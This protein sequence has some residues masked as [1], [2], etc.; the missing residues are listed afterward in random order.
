[1]TKSRE[2]QAYLNEVEQLV[3]AMKTELDQT[4]LLLYRAWA[5]T[6]RNCKIA[7]VIASIPDGIDFQ[8][9]QVDNKYSVLIA[10]DTHGN[11]YKNI[12]TKIKELGFDS[13]YKAIEIRIKLNKSRVDYEHIL[14]FLGNLPYECFYL[15]LMDSGN[16][17]IKTVRISEGGIAGTLVDLK[18]IY[19]IALDNYTTG[20]ILS[21]NHPSGN[22]NPSESDIILT[23]KIIEAGKLLD[24]NVIDHLIIGHDEYFSF[25]DDGIMG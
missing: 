10:N 3:H 22:L 19:K 15:I 18:K 11:N 12:T 9:K 14:P 16:Q 23:K 24:I 6:P 25:A 4:R 17:L 13:G 5:R 20:M 2:I 7:N 21:H 1:M 8:V